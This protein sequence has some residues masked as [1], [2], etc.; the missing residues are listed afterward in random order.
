[1]RVRDVSRLF[2]GRENTAIKRWS[3]GSPH[4]IAFWST[5]VERFFQ[6]MSTFTTRSDSLFTRL[7]YF[8]IVNGSQCIAIIRKP[9]EIFLSMFK[10]YNVCQR[11][12]KTLCICCVFAV[13]TFCAL[14][15]LFSFADGSFIFDQFWSI[16]TQAKSCCNTY[17]ISWKVNYYWNVT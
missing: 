10:I 15:K 5:Y 4:T 6:K 1:M 3:F 7:G 9:P 12:M 11:M 2:S 8:Q 13:C 16:S 14:G 17:K